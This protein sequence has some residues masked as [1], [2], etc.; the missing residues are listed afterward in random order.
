MA[1]FIK[2]KPSRPDL[3]VLDDLNRRI[4]YKDGGYG[5]RRTALIG[6]YIKDGDLEWVD[7]KEI[8]GAKKAKDEIEVKKA[9]EKLAKVLA[10]N[11]KD[12]EEAKAKAEEDAKARAELESKA[13]K[14]SK[15]TNK[16]G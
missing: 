3:I 11:K 9:K 1:Q 15:K 13:S 2:V 10:K 14:P 7:E 12:H 6:R 5:V 4:P 16:E 8:K